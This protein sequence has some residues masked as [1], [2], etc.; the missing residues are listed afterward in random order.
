MKLFSAVVILLM[1]LVS[2]CSQQVQQQ[3]QQQIQQPEIQPQQE[4]QKP[5]EIVQEAK[6][7]AQDESISSNEVRIL[8]K[9]GLEPLELKISLGN[10]V[11]W[12]NEDKKDIQFTVFKDGKFYLNSAIM[13][14]GEKFEYEFKEKGNYEYWTL[15]YGPQGAKIVVE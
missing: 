5:A 10:S 2:A 4:E 1:V 13:K 11:T 6:G 12:V 9:G 15:A 3:P 7:A 14:P 8:G